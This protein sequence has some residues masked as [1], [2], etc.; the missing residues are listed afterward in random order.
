MYIVGIPKEL[1]QNE[2]RV[3]LIPEDVAKLTANGIEV[4]IQ[5][6]AGNLAN[7]YNEEYMNVGAKI[8][9]TIEDIYK[10]CNFIIKVKEPQEYEYKLI[11]SSHTIFAFFHFAS[12]NKLQ[13]AMIN[14]GSTCYMPKQHQKLLGTDIICYPNF[15]KTERLWQPSLL[16]CI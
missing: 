10:N 9:N 3:S 4:Y 1:K 2:Q 8:C 6:D 12:N 14:S 13:N 16:I 15:Y 11:N 7:N 5:K